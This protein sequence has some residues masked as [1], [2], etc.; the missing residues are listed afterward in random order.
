MGGFLLGFGVLW[1]AF[2][3]LTHYRSGEFGFAWVLLSP[4]EYWTAD[5]QRHLL[6]TLSGLGLLAFGAVLCA[7]RLRLRIGLIFLGFLSATLLPEFYCGIQDL[8]FRSVVRADLE[9]AHSQDRWWP[10][11]EGYRLYY[12]PRHGIQ[13]RNTPTPR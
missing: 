4:Q 1:L 2:F 13:S 12:K 3:M 6:F 5:W 11:P 9:S 7:K 10:N 8:R